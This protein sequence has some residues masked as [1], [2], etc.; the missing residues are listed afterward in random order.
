MTRTGDRLVADYLKR[1]DR[2][3][4]DLPRDRRRE[5]RDEIASHIAEAR[6][7][8]PHE[9]EADVRAL[10]ERIG[11]PA[12]IASEARERFGIRRRR[13]GFV[14]IAALILLPIGGV[15]LPL[16]GWVAGVALLWAS[17]VWTTRDKIVGTLVVPGG[18]ALPLFLAVTPAYSEECGGEVDPQTGAM[19]ERCTGG[20]PEWLET[21]G[22]ILF[23]LLLAAPLA[24]AIYLA[25]R[26]R[27]VAPAA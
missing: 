8:L 25:V 4:S 1:L 19:T 20:P 24:T 2:A 6:A 14:E 26:M 9:S 16:V 27:R 7:D 11:E 3:L 23:V 13:T 17:A 22:P 21:L 12:E 5:L 15:V 10:L 18:L